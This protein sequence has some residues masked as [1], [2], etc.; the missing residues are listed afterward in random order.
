[1]RVRDRAPAHPSDARW[2]RI[3]AVDWPKV[4]ADLDAK[5]RP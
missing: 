3:A 5:A 2:M 4:G 1:M